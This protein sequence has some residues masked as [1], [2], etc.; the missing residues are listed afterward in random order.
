MLSRG[1][2]LKRFLGLRWLQSLGDFSFSLY[3][4]HAPI[5]LLGLYLS[6]FN[7]LVGLACL[8][9]SI[10]FSYLAFR[11]I[12]KPVQKLSRFVRTG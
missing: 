2:F 9:L 3:L 1:V 5:I 10:P 6:D 11:F 12:E 4:L 8:G 7:V